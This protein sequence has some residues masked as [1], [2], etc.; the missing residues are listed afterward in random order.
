MTCTVVMQVARKKIF[1]FSFSHF[2]IS[3]TLLFTLN[4][5][6]SMEFVPLHAAEQ[7]SLPKSAKQTLVTQLARSL[8][9]LLP[10]DVALHV[11]EFVGLEKPKPFFM[12][13]RMQLWR[14]LGEKKFIAALKETVHYVRSDLKKH[15]RDLCKFYMKDIRERAKVD[16]CDRRHRRSQRLQACKAKALIA[17][18]EFDLPGMWTLWE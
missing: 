11:A 18:E 12:K 2:G 5:Q 6:S 9:T 10:L 13:K 1:Y 16:A 3:N 15:I 17:R 4:K 7:A 14:M 8:V